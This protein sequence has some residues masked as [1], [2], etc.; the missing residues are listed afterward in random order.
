MTVSATSSYQDI[1]R[2]H[3]AA[4]QSFELVHALRKAKGR[5]GKSSPL[6]FAPRRSVGGRHHRYKTVKFLWWCPTTT[7]VVMPADSR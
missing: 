6:E 3:D 4:P 5:I 2:A 7:K 1:A